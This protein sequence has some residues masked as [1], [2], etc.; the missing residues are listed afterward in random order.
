MVLCLSITSPGLT[1]SAKPISEETTIEELPLRAETV[2]QAV[3]LVKDNDSILASYRDTYSRDKVVAFF[4]AITRSTELAV[5]VLLN[6]H[7]FDIPPSLAFALC[8]E[9]SRYNPK[10]ISGKNQNATIDRGLFQLNSNSFAQLTEA[11]FF[12]PQINAYYGM[13]YLRWCI[14]LG[15]SHA[16]GLAIYNAGRNRVLAGQIPDRTLKY[17]SRILEYQLQLEEHF[18]ALW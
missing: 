5:I 8:W 15:G 1:L 18:R 10:A 17:V 6:A 11:D 3:E 12:D 14:D 16:T 2:F 7:I 13:S 4:G 9:E